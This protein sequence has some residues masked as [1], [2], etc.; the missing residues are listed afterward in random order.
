MVK[1]NPFVTRKPRIY[2]VADEKL[3]KRIAERL[4]DEGWL[5]YLAVINTLIRETGYGPYGCYI[6][7]LG[8]KLCLIESPEPFKSFDLQG[9]YAEF[10]KLLSVA[11]KTGKEKDIKAL[12]EFSPPIYDFYP[13]N[14]RELELFIVFAKAMI[15]SWRKVTEI[16]KKLKEIINK[17]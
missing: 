11:E 8:N 9:Y 16:K 2:V 5:G 3:A 12:F 4:E 14:E 7:W 1:V 6:E 10:S 13:K 15:N 17:L